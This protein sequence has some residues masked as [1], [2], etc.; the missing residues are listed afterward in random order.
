M[1]VLTTAEAIQIAAHAREVA[2]GSKETSKLDAFVLR[3]IGVPPQEATLA[4]LEAVVLRSQDRGTR[5]TYAKRLRSV[6]ELLNKL[7]AIDNDVYL[8][9]PKL[10]HPKYLPRP[11]ADEQVDRLMAELPE[12]HRSAVQFALLTGAR[13]MEVYAFEG[14]HLVGGANG[15]EVLLHGK[16]GTRLT[17]PAHPKVV[18]LVN[19]ANTLGR[20]FPYK[21][22]QRVSMDAS[23]AIRKVLGPGHTFHMCRHTFGTRVYKASGNSLLLTQQLLRHQDVSSTLGYVLVS[24]NAPRAAVEL[25]TA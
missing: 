9:L 8:Q 15:Y 3:A 11:F 21:D 13:A 22:A 6:F 18:D 17:V 20:I 23:I 4:H 10:R 7:G 1:K 19:A 16:G 2:G 14:Q 12:P 25:L 24:E 5:A